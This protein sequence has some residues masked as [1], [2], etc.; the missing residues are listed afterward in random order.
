MTNNLSK[1]KLIKYK[2][3]LLEW[4]ELCPHMVNELNEFA[5]ILDE[6]F[7]KINVTNVGTSAA[8]IGG[9]VFM[10][11]GFLLSVVTFGASI[12]LSIIG[13]VYLNI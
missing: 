1:K 8:V 9:A 3:C 13:K 6:H 10:I 4:I 11:A 5:D 7:H 12:G 2:K